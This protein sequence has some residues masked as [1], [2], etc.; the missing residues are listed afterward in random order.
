MVYSKEVTAIILSDMAKGASADETRQH[1]SDLFGKAPHQN[2]IYA[3]RHSITAEQIVDELLR[4][5][6]RDITKEQNS[7]IRMRYR[8]KL[9][10]KLIPIKTEILSKSLSINQSEIKHVIELVDP[11]NPAPTYPPDEVQAARRANIIP[12]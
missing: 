2:T 1:L 8:D 3:H 10:E 12:P 6:E 9:L 11:D 7:E 4:Q 5:Q